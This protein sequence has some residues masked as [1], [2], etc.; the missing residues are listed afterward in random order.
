VPRP[1]AEIDSA[2][3]IAWTRERIA[4]Y[5]APRSIDIVQALPRNPN[6]KVLRR[7]LREP[8]WR[9]QARNVG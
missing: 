4:G 1:G 8:Y 6:G 9:G 3:L 7:V 2:R 5:K